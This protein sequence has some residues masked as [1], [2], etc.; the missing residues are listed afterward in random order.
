MLKH[1]KK[2]NTYLI[3]EQ[4]I[5]LISRLSFAKMHNEAKFVSSILKEHYSGNSLIAKEKKL[6][7]SVLKTKNLK[8]EEAEDI[9]REVFEESK[10]IEQETLNK[11]KDRLIND[12]T[13]KISVRFFEMPVNEY[14]LFASTQILFNESRDVGNKNTTPAERAKIKKVLVE[15]MCRKEETQKEYK[16]DNFTYN[17][18]VEKYNKKYSKL[19]TEEQKSL[20]KA[21]ILYNVSGNG[22]KLKNV[23]IENKK[24]I[25][26]VLRPH[27]LNE[28]I[29]KN[30]NYKMIVEAYNKIDDVPVENI[31]EEQLYTFMKYFDLKEDLEGILNG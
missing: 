11:Q 3:Y 25:K 8:K 30:E 15:R 1:N 14:K 12:I 28:K 17:I 18:L 10:E 16:I 29:K 4:F 27:L 2:R 13:N 26:N 19:M 6:F 20:L 22:S 24:K 7:E 9:L 31:T 21:W 23:L 5:S